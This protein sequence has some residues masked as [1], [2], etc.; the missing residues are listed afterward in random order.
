MNDQGCKIY[1]NC[2]LFP[3]KRE[4]KTGAEKIDGKRSL[5][6]NYDLQYG[7]GIHVAASEK[8]QDDI[9]GKIRKKELKGDSRE[10]NERKSFFRK[11]R[12]IVR[13]IL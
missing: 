12:V 6:E 5:A 3:V 7:N 8:E 2:K 9:L 10:D 13:L 11:Q 1:G 4:K